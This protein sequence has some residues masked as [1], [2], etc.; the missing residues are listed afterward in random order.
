M[1]QVLD[2]NALA[3][4][5][6]TAAC[7]AAHLERRYFGSAAIAAVAGVCESGRYF[8]WY[9]G[10]CTK[11]FEGAFAQ[12]HGRSHA[13]LMSSGTAALHASYFA[14]NLGPEDEVIL[15]ALTFI[16]DAS[17]I[18]QVGATPVYAEVDPH[19]WV[20][21][22]DDVER[23]ITAKTKAI[24]AVHMFG[25]PI[26]MTAILDIARR[27]NLY[28]IEDCGQAHGAKLGDRL[29]GTFGDIGSFSLA[30]RKHVTTGGQGGINIVNNPEWEARMRAFIHFGKRDRHDFV[31]EGCNYQITELQAAI[32]LVSLQQLDAELGRLR[33]N[34][35]RLRDALFDT[36]L[37]LDKEAVNTLHARFKVA[38]LLPREFSS[39]R[40]WFSSAL[41][42]E[43]VPNMYYPL[44][45]AVPWMRTHPYR[46]NSRGISEDIASRL[47]TIPTAFES[48]Y[49]PKVAE[50]IRKV[51]SCLP[52][53]TTTVG[54]L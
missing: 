25:Q 9:G 24:L 32:G 35:A 21:D 2:W 23:H 53:A 29:V 26:D 38:F 14:L 36:S 7:A 46:W 19:T 11:A 20:L 18:L 22:P 52:Y 37:Q 40:D 48:H 5:G 8:D 33:E 54:Q 45:P 16:A 15:P 4:N 1:Q 51:A 44:L 43:G 42:A 49:I 10:P 28:V 30:V 3:I 12:Y 47:I 50:A 34:G 39:L 27:H 31:S 6:G 41:S 17:T 13:V